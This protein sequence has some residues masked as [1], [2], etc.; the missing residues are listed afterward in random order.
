[1]L[2]PSLSRP[3]EAQCEKRKEALKQ[4]HGKK[5]YLGNCGC[6]LVKHCRGAN[7]AGPT[8]SSLL[9]IFLLDKL[10][11]ILVREADSNLALLRRTLASPGVGL[12]RLGSLLRLVIFA[13]LSGA[14]VAIGGSCT[15]MDLAVGL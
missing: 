5:V 12:G 7:L 2:Y 10:V 11:A 3:N 14:G 8:P 9:A 1:M 6:S 4:L 15:I 13:I